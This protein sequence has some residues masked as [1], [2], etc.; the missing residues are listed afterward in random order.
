[1]DKWH[2]DEVTYFRIKQSSGPGSQENEGEEM[3][4]GQSRLVVRPLALDHLQVQFLFVSSYS[5]Q[6]L[7]SNNLKHD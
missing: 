7:S 6:S 5:L 1:M 3:N 4:L 2:K